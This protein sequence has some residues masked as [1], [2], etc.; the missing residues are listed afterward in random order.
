MRGGGEGGGLVEREDEGEGER[1]E[2]KPLWPAIFGIDGNGGIRSQIG[3]G[4]S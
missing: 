4:G 3:G 1:G 2:G